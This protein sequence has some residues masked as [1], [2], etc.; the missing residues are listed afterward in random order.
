VVNDEKLFNDLI[1]YNKELLGDDKVI[2]ISEKIG[3][4]KAK[5][6][7][8]ED[9]GFVSQKVPAVSLSLVAGCGKDGFTFGNHHPKTRFDEGALSEGAAVY[10][11][12]AMKWLEENNK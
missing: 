4:Q 7:G 9:F 6:T 1:R 12:S 3:S 5:G 10:A 8:S 2:N 11:N